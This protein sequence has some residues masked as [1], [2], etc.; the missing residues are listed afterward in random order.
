LSK[1]NIAL[2]GPAGSG[3]SSVAKLVAKKLNIL[4]LDTGAMYRAVGYHVIKNKIALDDQVSIENEIDKIDMDVKF[5]NGH[6]AVY[7]NEKDI[8][9]K[10]RTPKISNAASKVSAYDKVR[11]KLVS[12]QQE[13][14]RGS[15]MILDG[16]DIGTVVLADSDSK[17]YLTAS[18]D[19]RAKRRWDQLKSNGVEI[20]LLELK[21]EIEARDHFD[22]TREFS[23]LAKAK[24]AIL[25]DTSSMSLDEVVE[26]IIEKVNKRG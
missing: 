15:D 24:D 8:T 18:S 4:Y 23:P 9:K 7:I 26:F 3:K 21:N 16:R 19:I 2:D 1:I 25:I 6:Q 13:I 10:I 20:D 17:F 12:I 11:R 22:S 14:A 5:E